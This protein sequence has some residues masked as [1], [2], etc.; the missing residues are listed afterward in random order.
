MLDAPY[1]PIM[2]VDVAYRIQNR[3]PSPIRDLDDV[4][5]MSAVTS[6]DGIS[7]AAGTEGTVVSVIGADDLYVVEFAEPEGTL[8]TVNGQILS[9]VSRAAR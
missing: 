7:L 6:D 9:V 5:L 4:V 8:A 3:P 2:S 1:H